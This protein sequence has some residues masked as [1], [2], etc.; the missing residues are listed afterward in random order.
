MSPDDLT[1]PGAR[2]SAAMV[3]TSFS[4]N[5]LVACVK[6]DVNYCGLAGVDPFDRDAR[7]AGV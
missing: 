5:I 7:S 1:I 6:T 3:L 4:Q 2:P